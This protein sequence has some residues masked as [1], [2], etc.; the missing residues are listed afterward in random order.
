MKKIEYYQ[1]FII[2]H[3]Y[4]RNIHTLTMS[5]EEMGAELFKTHGIRI[6]Y[7]ELSRILTA[8]L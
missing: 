5:R 6:H 7:P 2:K 8:V 3:N 4:I 1:P